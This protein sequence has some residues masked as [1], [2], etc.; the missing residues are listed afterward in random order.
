MFLN[1]RFPEDHRCDDKTLHYADMRPALP[2]AGIAFVLAITVQALL[3]GPRFE[4]VFEAGM[5]VGA[6]LVLGV[7]PPR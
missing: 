7:G 2:I 3:G 5:I 4:A 1:G 6:S